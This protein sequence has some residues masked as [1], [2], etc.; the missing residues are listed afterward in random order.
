MWFAGFVGCLERV[1]EVQLSTLRA[2]TVLATSAGGFAVYVE[3]N[4]GAL[5]SPRGSAP[6]LFEAR[7]SRP[8][9]MVILGQM[10][11]CQ[12][13]NNVPERCKIDPRFKL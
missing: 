2:L 13:T 5:V 7:R 1:R 9:L 4:A 12:D 8:I 3:A 6:R 11:A 10:L